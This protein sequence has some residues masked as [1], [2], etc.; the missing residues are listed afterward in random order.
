MSTE[1][2]LSQIRNISDFPVL[3]RF[4][5]V[6]WR[7]DNSFHGAAVMVGA[8]FSRC[9]ANSGDATKKLPLW[10][11]L[12]NVLQK[13]LKSEGTDPLRI[14]EEYSAY[15]GKQALN[16]LIK[17]ELND[18][19]WFPGQLHN[20]LL[21]LPW[22]EVLTTNWDSLLE[23]ASDRLQERFYNLVNRQED[24]SSARSPRIVKLHGTVNVTNELIFTQED[25]RTYPASH[26]AFVNFARQVFIENELC[27]I[28]F[29]GDD[30]NFLQW[31]G[32][33]RDH[34]SNSARKIYLVGALGLTAAKR[35]YLESMNIAPI[36]LTELVTQY[37]DIDLKHQKASEIFLAALKALKP[38]PI[39]NWRPST[40]NYKAGVK[41]KLLSLMKDRNE[42]PG[43]LICPP[44]LRSIY[45]NQL[46]DSSFST[47]EA[48]LKLEDDTR[49]EFL[50]EI[51][52]RHKITHKV[53]PEWLAL[54]MLKICNPAKKN[55]LA[56]KQ[57]LEIA[58]HILRNTRWSNESESFYITVT[59]IIKNNHIFSSDSLFEMYFF[60][61][62]LA[63]KKFQYKEAE[64]TVSKLIPVNPLQKIRK[65]QLLAELGYH[66]EGKQLI[67]DAY[68][69]LLGQFRNSPHSI[70]LLSRL[71]V[72]EYL[73]NNILLNFKT[74]K[75]TEAS[76]EKQCDVWALFEQLRNKI[77]KTID[78]KLEGQRIE[79]LF[80]PGSYKNKPK[81]NNS[82][83]H[84]MLDLHALTSVT[85]I[86][87]RWD[88]MNYMVSEASD[89]ASLNELPIEERFYL[90]IN[91]ANSEEDVV[92][93][94]TFSRLQ[95]ANITQE[96]SNHLI[97]NCEGAI[98]YWLTKLSEQSK[99]GHGRALTRLRIFIE[100]LARASTRATPEQAKIILNMA[101]GLGG[102][103]ELH[104]FWVFK[105]L[106]HLINYSLES[107]PVSEH[108]Q[109]LLNALNF[110]LVTELEFNGP[111]HDWPN[112][113]IR[114]L[115][116]RVDSFEL[117][118]RINKIIDQI[119]PNSKRS[120]YS[121][122]RL[123]PL[124]KNRF[125][126]E[127]ELDRI[128]DNIWKESPDFRVLPELGLL[129]W[130]LLELPSRDNECVRSLVRAHLFQAK[131]EH[132]FDEDMLYD[133]ISAAEGVQ[134]LCSEKEALIYFDHF[135]NW[136][137]KIEKRIE[138]N[139]FEDKGPRSWLI[140]K[141]I[142]KSIMPVLPK[143]ALN[144]ENFNKILQFFSETQL[145]EILLALPYFSNISTQTK[146]DV[147]RALYQG[148]LD[149]NDDMVRQASFSLLQWCRSD[150]CSN[151]SN[152]TSQMINVINNNRT[153]ALPSLIWVAREMF[154]DNFLSQTDIETLIDCIP[155][156]FDSTN[157]SLASH[158][159][160]KIV[161]IS[162]LRSE[163]VKLS[164]E[165]IKGT[166]LSDDRYEDL[167]RVI[168]EAK[169]D[170]LPEV[171]FAA[172]DAK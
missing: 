124:I 61:A 35:K 161:N 120:S 30:P 91:A 17:K 133:L 93:E 2:K 12:S 23:R 25:Y 67:V 49:V 144:Q 136:R 134:E 121:I 85:G 109:L 171:R 86:P 172:S 103:K 51:A 46:Y 76:R 74:N 4:A 54:E 81:I 89:L 16:E 88:G 19:A 118:A 37:D 28:G 158:T 95:M 155:R 142:S 140:A 78:S 75:L 138:S 9:S 128:A 45:I 79:V 170:A 38:E 139:P 41:E 152:L 3:E 39:W 8:G 97:S 127:D 33:V 20:E 56:K 29:S 57:Q 111:E 5:S 52:W 132:L 117:D 60:Q 143:S 100:V 130:V 160:D 87:I 92:I 1:A 108:A 13:E 47:Q 15:F 165:T 83:I 129:T 18:S 157:Y 101:L 70:Y 137:P 34:L 151:I 21:E 135:I 145:S 122:E 24:L 106:N 62:E 163:C 53:T 115:T 131:K 162:L 102:R 14:A 64:T 148:L 150:G 116:N 168:N 71:L 126:R 68:R 90:A 6:L 84:P 73:H 43:W 98:Q 55:V 153:S 156:V 59:D 164:I 104:H 149:S 26:A 10:F 32:W 110:P 27:L 146:N 77:R 99:I 58:V 40:L 169:D 166:K 66:D 96:E 72:A 119:T 107:I 105:A 123:I 167:K 125:L 113:I 147:Q 7:S 42:Y 69:E 48:L 141:V 80:E 65:A 159:E 154:S 94:R 114:H 11:D 44:V 63:L 82:E 31:A 50:Y 112:P 22:T 36:D